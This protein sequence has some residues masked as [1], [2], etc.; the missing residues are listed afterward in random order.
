[1]KTVL[2][3]LGLALLSV[4][5]AQAIDCNKAATDLDNAICSH[6]DLL[7]AD[8]AMSDAY[9]AALKA[10]GP[11]MAKLIKADQIEWNQY[12]YADCADDDS[13]GTPTADTIAQCL[14]DDTNR[15]TA[16]LAGQP[17]EGP[18]IDEAALPQVLSGADDI[19]NEYVRFDTP[20][21]PMTKA[22]DLILKTELSDVKMARGDDQVSDWY[23]LV[24]HYASP[25]LMSVEIDREYDQGYA[26]P[27][28]YDYSINLD[29]DG[30]RLTVSDAFDDAAVKKLEKLCEAQLQDYIAA[31]EEGAD[32]R[33]GQ[34]DSIVD[35]LDFWTFGADKATTRFMEYGMDGPVT[36]ELGYDVLR[37]LV[38]S[39]FPLPA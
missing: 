30:K 37:P 9:T 12:R 15:R 27:M 10:V 13:N 14:V 4:T 17:V 26:H 7:A 31:G 34:V 25:T 8:N 38:K 39:G 19:F 1:M 16:W 3:G 33:L 23:Q 21:S 36:C 35:D 29:A 5:A 2:L 20:K 32:I 6:P 18:G 22:F 24:L 11:K 28:T